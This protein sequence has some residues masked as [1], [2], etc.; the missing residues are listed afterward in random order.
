VKAQ[1]CSQ[2]VVKSISLKLAATHFC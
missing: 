1:N 2:I